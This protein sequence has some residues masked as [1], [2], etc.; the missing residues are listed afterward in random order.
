MKTI[1]IITNGRDYLKHVIDSIKKNDLDGYELVIGAEPSAEKLRK[2]IE[3]INFIKTHVIWN[4]TNLGPKVNPLNTINYAFDTLKSE[5]NIYTEDDELMSPDVTSIANWYNELD[6]KDDYLML[7]FINKLGVLGD[8]NEI[9]E[10]EGNLP[11]IRI[12]KNIGTLVNAP[13]HIISK[14]SWY[15]KLKP[16]WMNPESGWD[17]N[18]KITMQKN[19]YTC[20][21]PAFNRGKDI[22]VIGVHGK[23]T[24]ITRMWDKLPWN[25]N[26]KFSNFYISKFPRNESDMK[27]IVQKGKQ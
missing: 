22:G 16:V 10:V 4:K 15:N 12:D 1:T 24:S 19:N 2:Y 11:I 6:N 18:T 20:L 3:S 7:S 8:G 21:V 25:E 9:L 27:Y 14:N 17:G 5:V 23:E 26:L 13:T